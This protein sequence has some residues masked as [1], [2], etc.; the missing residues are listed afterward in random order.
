MAR[1]IKHV[2]RSDLSYGSSGDNYNDELKEKGFLDS[3]NATVDLP[4]GKTISFREF[5][6]RRET[7]AHTLKLRA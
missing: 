1:E 4:E 2:T 6:S 7:V 5:Q 3:D